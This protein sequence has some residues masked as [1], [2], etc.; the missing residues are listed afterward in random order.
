MSISLPDLTKDRSQTC[1]RLGLS[2]LDGNLGGLDLGGLLADLVLDS[3][4]L[5]HL[6]HSLDVLAPAKPEEAPLPPLEK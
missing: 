5:S 2:L 3:G 4:V 1:L 6:L